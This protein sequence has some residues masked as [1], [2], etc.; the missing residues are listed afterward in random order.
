MDDNKF[1]RH[2]QELIGEKEEIAEEIV[3]HGIY[4]VVIIGGGPA[5]LTAGIYCARA[6]LKTILLAEAGLGG[7]VAMTDKIENYPGFIGNSGVELIGNMETQAREFGLQI[8]PFKMVTK[9]ALEGRLKEVY[10][11]NDLYPCYAVILATGLKTVELNLPGETRFKGKGVSY[12]AICDANFFSGKRVAVVGG[13]DTAIEEAVYLSKFASQV[14]IIH[15]RDELR[16]AK[17]VQETA[18][19]NEKITFFWSHIV[20]DL[21]GKHSLEGV[22]LQDLKTGNEVKLD[23]DGLFVAVGSRPYTGFLKNLVSLDGE[24]F[25]RVSDR[26]ETSVPG[27]FAA[28]DI[29]VT[30]LRQVSTAVG[31]GAIAAISAERFLSEIKVKEGCEISIG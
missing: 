9:V 27:I 20:Q 22:I 1:S 17:I 8:Q 4:D 30:P 19:C 13:G 26:M 25:V 15:R 10:A 28:G 21:I 14:F 24:G 11:G 3:K 7:Q 12:C 23:V 6:R 18:F 31:D 16:A 5:G 2:I 29:R